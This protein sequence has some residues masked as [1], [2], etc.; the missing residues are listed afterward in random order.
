M[1]NNVG[2]CAQREI[3]HDIFLIKW[4]IFSSI[5]GNSSHEFGCDVSFQWKAGEGRAELPR[6]TETE[7]RW[8]NHTTK[9][10]QTAEPDAE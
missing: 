5:G 6:G 1:K 4:V 10:R 7:A 8:R 9:S 2:Y 3:T